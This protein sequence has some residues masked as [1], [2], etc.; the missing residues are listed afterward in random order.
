MWWP[1]P[2]GAHGVGP[3]RQQPH[4]G[5]AGGVS[6]GVGQVDGCLGTR[7]GSSS[8]SQLLKGSAHGLS[9]CCIFT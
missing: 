5:G 3:G 9:P 6:G 1:A 4:R 8:K 7:E 2:A